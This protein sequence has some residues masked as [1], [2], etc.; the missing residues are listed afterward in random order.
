[1]DECAAERRSAEAF[2]EK[3][4]GPVSHRQFVIRS[5]DGG[6]D[7]VTRRRER[8]SGA[9]GHRVRVHDRGGASRQLLSMRP[10]A[11]RALPSRRREDLFRVSMGA[12]FATRS[13]L[14]PSLA[15]RAKRLDGISFPWGAGSERPLGRSIPRRKR[16]RARTGSMARHVSMTESAHATRREPSSARRLL[17]RE[18]PRLA[19]VRS[20]V[21]WITGSPRRAAR[22]RA[23]GRLAL[24][25][26][27]APP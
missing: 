19:R 14:T 4:K 5:R 6:R 23:R 26:S 25:P 24:R 12:A 1:M 8:R 10:S 3:K 11:P 9:V 2:E 7:G 16:G 21:G 13:I 15:R 27:R 17:G 20:R 18:A 22:R